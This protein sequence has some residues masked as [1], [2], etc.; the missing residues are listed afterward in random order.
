[1]TFPLDKDH[2]LFLKYAKH[3]SSGARLG[4][5]RKKINSKVYVYESFVSK[6]TFVRRIV[7]LN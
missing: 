6:T 7:V 4:V 1:M 2:I 3:I 5:S